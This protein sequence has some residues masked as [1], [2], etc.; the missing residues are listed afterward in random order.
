MQG[1]WDFALIGERPTGGTLLPRNDV[2]S[3]I[4]PQVL[5]QREHGRDQMGRGARSAVIKTESITSYPR[6]SEKTVKTSIH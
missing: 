6:R 1:E 5:V 2:E 4:T 3:Y